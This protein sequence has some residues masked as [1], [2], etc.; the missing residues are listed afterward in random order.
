MKKIPQRLM[1]GL[2]LGTG[3]FL[4]NTVFGSAVLARPEASDEKALEFS[5]STVK[6]STVDL[7]DLKGKDTIF[8]FFTT[9]CPYC[10]EKF[11]LLAK[12][13][14]T[15]QDQ[16]VRFFAINVG[17]SQA[18]V[19]SFLEKKDVPFEVLLDE[20]SAVARSYGVVGVP[21]FVLVNKEGRVVY[22]G[23]DMPGDYRTCF[24]G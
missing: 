13:Y 19:A 3:I 11:P 22:D 20:K 16:G 9:W 10:R 6:G 24:K 8:F 17:E 4:V 5:L 21:T 18:K 12:E 2:V 1:F 14:K 23:N 15:Y 7:K